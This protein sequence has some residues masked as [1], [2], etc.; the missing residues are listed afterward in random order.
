MEL[1]PVVYESGTS[2]MI[3]TIASKTGMILTVAIGEIF[4]NSLDAGARNVSAVYNRELATWDF[5][6]DG[7]GTTEVGAIVTP[8]W[9]EEHDT[10]L[11]GRYG[12]G[13]TAA[14]LWLTGGMGTSFV[15]SVT[16][17]WVSEVNASFAEMQ[18]RDALVAADGR[19]PNEGNS[20][21]TAIHLTGA[22][23]HKSQEFSAAVRDLS[24]RFTPALRKG[25]GMVINQTQLKAYEPPE[26]IKHMRFAFDLDGSIVKARFYLVKP[27]VTN[28]GGGFNIIFGHRII[29]TYTDPIGERSLDPCRIYCEV[30]LDTKTWKNINDQKTGFVSYPAALM[31]RLSL[32]CADVFEEI[33][34]EEE[35]IE[36]NDTLKE[37]QAMLDALTGH[38]SK[39]VK[40]RR[41]SPRDLDEEAHTRTDTGRKRTNLKDVQ[42]GS[43]T[44]VKHKRIVISKAQTME[45]P[46]KVNPEEKIVRFTI[47]MNH[48]VNQLYFQPQG[49]QFLY[50]FII[51]AVTCDRHNRPYDYRRIFPRAEL[52]TMAREFAE[53]LSWT[54]EPESIAL[55]MAGVNGD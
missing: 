37:A 13:G 46:F 17:D 10:T 3:R 2:Q 22:L 26:W 7:K 31:D 50:R 5:D 51:L 16:R 21:G 30:K 52:K 19:E 23:P 32:E 6:D 15:R 11:S 42:P 55:Q 4:D 28:R 24:F 18:A 53:M 40:E 49:A 54:I 41:Q 45:E 9:H 39:G 25:H 29:D 1:K 35:Y 8:Y 12:L 48:P 44:S 36:I 20:T 33:R 14:Q 27:R 34:E 38:G 47:A 43:N